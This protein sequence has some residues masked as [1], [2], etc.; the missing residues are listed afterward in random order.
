MTNYD[1]RQP[2]TESEEAIRSLQLELAE[3]NRGLIALSWE[4]E[5]RVDERTTQLCVARDEL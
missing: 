2:L 3:T 1:L 4:L 5:R